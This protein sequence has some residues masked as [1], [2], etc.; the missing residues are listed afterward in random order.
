[1]RADWLFHPSSLIPHPCYGWHILVAAPRQIHDDHAFERT[2]VAQQPS[3]GM[4][5]LERR[6]DPLRFAQ[7]VE[8]LEREVVAAVVVLDAPS[9]LQLRVFGSDRWVIESRGNGMGLGD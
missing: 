1:M 4:R 6:N 7:L 3:E 2:A 8:G 9:A 5:R